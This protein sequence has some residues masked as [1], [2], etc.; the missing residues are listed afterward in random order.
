MTQENDD[1]SG[2]SMRAL[3][4]TAVAIGGL[5]WY[6]GYTNGLADCPAR[7]ERIRESQQEALDY[8]QRTRDADRPTPCEQDWQPSCERWH[9]IPPPMDDPEPEPRSRYDY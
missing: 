1:A 7:Q 9:G 2:F 4:V 8:L 6:F 5:G 3:I